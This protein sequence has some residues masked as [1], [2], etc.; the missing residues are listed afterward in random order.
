[1]EVFHREQ[2]GR[3]L[4]EPLG[5]GGCLAAGAV[6]VAARVVGDA[7]LSTAGQRASLHLQFS[8]RLLAKLADSG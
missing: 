3:T 5:T 4:V 1:M 6:A 8:R 7:L 2:L